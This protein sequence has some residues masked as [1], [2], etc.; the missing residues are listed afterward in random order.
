MLKC[1]KL[2]LLIGAAS[3]TIFLSL[4]FQ[5]AEHVRYHMSEEARQHVFV[6]R[7]VLFYN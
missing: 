2:L 3:V 4:C 6:T 7:W 1:I 5:M